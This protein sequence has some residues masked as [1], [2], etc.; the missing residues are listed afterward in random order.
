MNVLLTYRPTEKPGSLIKE[1]ISSTSCCMEK[2]W[3]QVLPTLDGFFG[4]YFFLLKSFK[5]LRW[6]EKSYETRNKY[7]ETETSNLILF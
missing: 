3:H 1:F 6:N 7:L 2:T 4:V 5:T